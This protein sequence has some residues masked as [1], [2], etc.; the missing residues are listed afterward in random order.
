LKEKLAMR[1]RLHLLNMQITLAYQQLQPCIFRPCLWLVELGFPCVPS[2]SVDGSCTGRFGSK[3]ADVDADVGS[4]GGC[5]S[6]SI[7]M[8]YEI[9]INDY[10]TFANFI[11]S[12]IFYCQTILEP[13]KA[14][15][16]PIDACN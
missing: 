10:A 7:I 15:I 16:K 9:C 12:F 2:P 1:H 11:F 6:S 4:I 14:L 8:Y 5:T 13:R 3:P